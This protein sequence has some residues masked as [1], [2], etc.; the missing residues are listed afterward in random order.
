[1]FDFRSKVSVHLSSL[2]LVAMGGLLAEDLNAQSVVIQGDPVAATAGEAVSVTVQYQA[3]VDGLIQLQ[4][5]DTDWKRAVEA[6][7]KVSAGDGTKTF[8][9]TVPAGTT[10]GDGYLWQALLYDAGWKKQAEVVRQ[11]VAVA[12]GKTSGTQPAMPATDAKTSTPKPKVSS[13][14][15]AADPTGK[16]RGEVTS[17]QASQWVPAGD[18]ELDWADEFSGKGMPDKWFPLLGY[19]PPEFQANTSKGIRWSG[20]TE[21]SA[22][23]YSTK[24]GNHVLDGKGNLVLRI[25]ADKTDTNEHGPKVNSAYLLTGYPEVWDSSEPNNAKWGGKFVS[26]KDGPLYICANVRTDQV[27]GYSTWFAFWLFTETRAYNGKPA[28]GAEV[29]IVEIVKGQPPYMSQ[30]FNVANHWSKSGGSESKQ[31]NAASRP[32]PE[33]YVDVNDGEF[34]QYGLEWSTDSMKCYV[35]GKLYY[36]FTENIPT[37]PVDMMVLLT[38]E[39]QP[40]SWD[41]NQGDGRTEGPFVSDT[42]KQREMSRAIVDYVRVFKKK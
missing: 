31:F 37:D 12:A 22:W 15:V 4:L 2:I 28:D 9:L 10:A 18:W 38:L 7:E 35:D 34:H 42:P 39:F 11:G 17:D 27:V 14:P 40:N 21:E 20:S 23:M 32:R 25:V 26:A 6:T 16:I 1:M 24:T 41:P 19:N 3:K 29:D 33:S 8:D 36:T 5:F 30:V 13:A